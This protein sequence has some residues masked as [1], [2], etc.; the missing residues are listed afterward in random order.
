MVWGQS[1]TGAN[2]GQALEG[3]DS[4]DLQLPNGT[5]T[6]Y[7]MA[8]D[9]TKDYS[10]AVSTSK[11]FGG[12]V[13][14][15][16]GNAVLNGEAAAVDLSLNN[17]NCSDVAFAGTNP[18]TNSPMTLSGTTGD[19][20]LPPVK[21][22]FCS[23]IETL[24]TG[25]QV[26]ADS[27]K[28]PR[29]AAR[30]A[31]ISSFRVKLRNHFSKDGQRVLSPEGGITGE[32]VEMIGDIE[33]TAD[34]TTSPSNTYGGSIIKIPGL[35][36]GMPGTPFHMTVEM[37]VGSSDC[38]A[39]LGVRQVM[40]KELPSGITS[41]VPASN[42]YFAQASTDHR[43][44]LAVSP[45]S[46]CTGRTATTLPDHAFAA[47]DG[48]I[49][50]PYIICSVPQW[51]EINSLSTNFSKSF[52]LQADLDFNPYSKGLATATLPPIF[53]C[54]EH[55]TN[56]TPV[57]LANAG[58]SGPDFS[59][60]TVYTF[61]GNFFGSGFSI[62]NLRFRNKDLS[63][64]GLFASIS[65][66][67]EIGDFNI[68][69]AEIEASDNVGVIAGTTQGSTNPSN[70]SLWSINASKVDIEARSGNPAIDSRVGGI[71]GTS[72]N[73]N[74]WRVTIKD[75]RIRGENSRVAGVIGQANYTNLVEVAAEV[76][77]DANSHIYPKYYVGGV[78]GSGS[79][80][81]M[82]YVKHE[83]AIYTNAKKVGGIIG[84]AEMTSSLTNFYAKS[85]VVTNDSATDVNIGGVVGYWAASSGAFGKGYS[86]SQ[87]RS[88]CISACNQGAMAGFIQTQ[89]STTYLSYHLPPNETGHQ[90]GTSFPQQT[91]ITLIPQMR[92]SSTFGSTLETVGD[93]N[94]KILN[95]EY[96]RFDFENHPCVNV[97]NGVS[98][99]GSG[100]GTQTSPKIICNEAQYLDLRF[101]TANTYHKLAST[102]RLSNAG[103]TQYDIP[104]FSAILDG[105][106]K[107]LLGGYSNISGAA[108]SGHFGTISSGAII[109][110]LQVHGLGRKANTGETLPEAH[111]AFAAINNGRLENLRISTFSEYYKFGS[112]V[113]GTNAATG[114]M[115]NIRADGVL[116]GYYSSYASLAVVNN[117]SIEDSRT[118]VE[119]V[120]IEGAGCDKFSGLV[121]ENNG[122]I[123]RT[124][125][126]SRLRGDYGF[127]ATNASMVV[128]T[129]NG[130]IED[131][132]VSQH[133]EFQV[134]DNPN[135]FHRI[136]SASGVLKRVVNNG[137][138]MALNTNYSPATI[139]FPTP[140]SASSPGQGTHT[141]VLRSGGLSGKL[142][143]RDTP[144]TCDTV[145]DR[146]QIMWGG[147]PDYNN[148]NGAF[149]GG[150]YIS[151]GQKMMA[152]ITFDNDMRSTER[153]LAYDE[154]NYG[155]TITA[156]RCPLGSTGKVSL[157][158]TDDLA[159]DL[160]GNGTTGAMLPQY[161]S[162]FSN[163]SVG[164][165]NAIWDANDPD[166]MQE[167]LN[168]HAYIMGVSTTPVLPKAWE[169][170]DNGELRLFN[171]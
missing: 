111:G 37:F 66:F 7:A 27:K 96:P 42:K 93:N 55:G 47:G 116:R 122:S 121:V 45:A 170:E 152:E 117:G 8:W 171:D 9:G 130:L 18:A 132:L 83:G 69:G 101:A 2:F 75:G 23:S 113:V 64:V 133:A 103:T 32:C 13:K 11:K 17:D 30:K 169:L 125:M 22:N 56:F 3:S 80:V 53:Q 1:S 48:S 119:L 144:F 146:L 151:L 124:E 123:K 105:N 63:G 76:N 163:Y 154:T 87:V 57:G 38:D 36:A 90:N 99:S 110:N 120:C 73:T 25:S 167:I 39:S 129:N 92:A 100:A 136:N 67:S 5:W 128:D 82:D 84:M 20:K 162:Y 166:D 72:D 131:V 109:K 16:K 153:V 157:W 135:Y 148:W 115:K 59:P 71:I 78:I 33:K 70:I 159:M 68:I 58:C 88:G 29:R 155:F 126:G 140:A 50:H 168:Y 41:V 77:I 98:I 12:T 81:I 94:W 156:S 161:A 118:N 102:I 14:C 86:L 104:T 150:G 49:E 60:G 4:I 52:K 43:Q 65:G 61:T 143:V 160:S 138:L 107:M 149:A 51:H 21:F 40:T 79:N 44:Y 95:G 34:A 137:K 28:D 19:K 31:P 10:G 89:P 91:Q 85:L 62:K 145:N 54:L 134:A 46:V 142:V 141:D 106:N 165:Q 74:L 147:I 114:V 158:Y 164:F 6:F 15:A 112:A 108:P 35:P 97:V 127:P 26:C 139:G 24:T